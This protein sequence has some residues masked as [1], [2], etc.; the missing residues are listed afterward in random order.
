MLERTMAAKQEQLSVDLMA[1]L[2]ELRGKVSDRKLR[3]FAADSVSAYWGRQQFWPWSESLPVRIVRDV[4]EGKD[5]QDRLR[6]VSVQFFGPV[7]V[8]LQSFL[9]DSS[10]DAAQST[11]EQILANVEDEAR[12]QAEHSVS[13]VIRQAGDNA[14]NQVFVLEEVSTDWDKDY[15]FRSKGDPRSFRTLAW[16]EAW[17]TAGVALQ[18]AFQ[19]GP[20]SFRRWWTLAAEAKETAMRAGTREAGKSGIEEWGAAGKAVEDAIRDVGQRAVQAAE[21]AERASDFPDQVRER[22]DRA[23]QQARNKWERRL[24]GLLYELI[25]FPFRP[26]PV[27]DPSWQSWDE[28]RIRKMAQTIYDECAFD[29]LPILADALEDAGCD[30]ADIL[31]HCRSGGEH[32]R[33]CWVV[34]LLLNKS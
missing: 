24:C 15:R 3:L 30:N 7:S 31:M 18:Q 8:A 4:A 34:D 11:C 20:G 1:V 12:R 25:G 28:N 32:V 6:N 2:E 22:I 29:D 10:W 23:R 5:T 19:R 17:R 9:A 27:I 14:G 26:L 16:E 13:H 21:E 33:G